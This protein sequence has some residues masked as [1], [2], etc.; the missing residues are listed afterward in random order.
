MSSIPPLTINSISERTPIP[1]P[2]ACTIGLCERG[3][4]PDSVIVCDEVPCHRRCCSSGLE[5]AWGPDTSWMCVPLPDT[6]TSP[7]SMKVTST[8]RVTST[9]TTREPVRMNV[10]TQIMVSA[11][12]NSSTMRTA[13]S[14]RAGTISSAQPTFTATPVSPGH[15]THKLAYISIPVVLLVLAIAGFAGCRRSREK[16]ASLSN[17]PPRALMRGGGTIPVNGS[18]GLGSNFG[19]W[20]KGYR[21][22][23]TSEL[24]TVKSVRVPQGGRAIGGRAGMD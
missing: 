22:Y 4:Y 19:M 15:S 10:T 23:R 5:C 2:D 18:A 20:T 16:P 7:S 9:F 8:G 12:T 14:T 11:N 13:T 21:A 3:C 6:S 1:S 24:S 17:I